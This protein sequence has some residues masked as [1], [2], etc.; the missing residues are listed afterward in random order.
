VIDIGSN[1]VR[2]VVYSGAQR[3]PDVW[4]NEK[5]AARLGRE[6]ADTGRISD[7]SADMALVALRRFDALLS[8]LGVRQVEV[9]AT[10]AARDASNGAE[11]LDKVR[12]LGL[13]PRLL[14]GEEEARASACGV[15]SA[16]PD[17]HGVVADL[18]GGSLELVSVEG[19]QAHQ[20]VSLPLGTLRLGALRKRG[21]GPFKDTV[22]AA[23]AQ[24]GWAAAHPGPL[25]MVG[26]TWRAFAQYAMLLQGHPLHDTH[27]LEIAV[28]QADLL[29]RDLVRADPAK[30]KEDAGLATMRATSLPDA[31]ALLRVM[32]T[33]LQPTGLVFSSWG[34]REG[35]LHQ[36]LPPLARRQDP[37]LVGVSHFTA[38]RGGSISRAATIAGW[39]AD[40]ARGEG[41]YSERLRLAAIMLALA[42]ARLEPNIRTRHALDWALHKRWIGLDMGG[43]ARIAAALVGACDKPALSSELLAL[44]DEPLLREALGW[45]LAVRLCRRL[46]G[47]S[48][49]SLAG[50]AL[51]VRDS[52]LVLWFDPTQADLLADTVRADLAAL[53]KWLGMPCEIVVGETVV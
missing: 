17:A 44:A 22:H 42:A 3:A 40:V 29:A 52:K 41:G 14:T 48:R 8:G 39:T 31:A 9:V 46:G 27:G 20:G 12:A 21:V 4:L 51:R 32:L 7:K 18:G 28:E 45:G 13:E 11:F 5:V 6:L 33:E 10:A 24:E 19:E 2:L 15:I 36:K 25:Y 26:G 50:S 34:L 23:L 47:G 49:L 35:L 16:F 38:P 43:R 1:T 30:L 53:A 37:L